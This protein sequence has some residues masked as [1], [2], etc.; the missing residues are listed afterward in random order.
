MFLKSEYQESFVHQTLQSN[1]PSPLLLPKVS[2]NSLKRSRI[3][4]ELLSS[5]REYVEDL[6]I[7]VATCFDRLNSAGW[8]PIEQKCLLIR[9]TF[10]LLTFQLAFL[11]EM[12]ERVKQIECQKKND[13]SE[14]KSFGIASLFLDINDKFNVYTHY[15]TRHD[16]ALHTLVE[17]EKNPEM[18]QCLKDLKA[19]SNRR[20][21]IRD[22]LIK[23]VQ[24]ICRYPILLKVIIFT[25]FNSI[26]KGNLETYSKQE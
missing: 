17:L 23:P 11:K 9:N 10:E 2:S 8:L 16:D 25:N 6:R 18:N 3:I 19:T 14:S 1:I 26:E 5:E 21:E 4:H 24:R 20:L 7:L 22:F 13:T 15:C 12:E